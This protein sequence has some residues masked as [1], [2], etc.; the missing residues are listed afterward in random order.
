MQR[1]QKTPYETYPVDIE[2]EA[3]NKQ[4]ACSMPTASDETK[5]KTKPLTGD[6]LE[7]ILS[8][9]NLNEAAKRVVKNKG[10]HGVDG[11]KIDELLPYLQQHGE[12][13]RGLLLEEEY[14]PNPVRR[15]EI[16]KPNG[17]IRL[18][19]IPTVIDRF[20]QQA[21]AQILTLIFDGSFS[22]NSYGFRPRK[23]AQMAV[24]KA[25][26]YIEQGYTWT[27]D[28]DLEKFF[29]KVNH[30]ILMSRVARKVKDKR[31]LRL[32]RR[33]L[34]SGIMLNGITIIKPDEGTPQGGPL[35][36]L[37][38]NILLDDLDKELEKRGHKF[39]RYADDCNIYVKS[40]RSGERVLESITNFLE[41]KLKLKVNKEKSAVDRP[42]KRKFL[43]FTFYSYYG[44]TGIL[45]HEKSMKRLKE[46]IKDITN[47]NVSRS[48]GSRMKSLNQLITGW[49]NYFRIAAMK[50][51]LKEI[52]G[53]TRRRLRACVWKQWKKIKTRYRNLLKF[54]IS[55]GKAWEYANTRKGYWRISNSPIL[56]KTLTNQYWINQGFKS[57]SLQYKAFSLS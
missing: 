46:K 29:D 49:V 3:R 4:E 44:K 37:L 14:R 26:E 31:V 57:F 21:I 28:M 50:G 9:R 11:M 32:I 41:T 6:L 40:R 7:I 55:D 12:T 35:S 16:P 42:W 39:C 53:W 8:S 23:S 20:I 34:E 43:G 45:P 1:P 38:S 10:S 27:V 18:L 25:K 5:A 47:R 56:S 17:G 19:G 33:Y 15:V 2:M 54:K 51:K 36:P 48:M 13:L 22:E 52:D 24:L 30:D